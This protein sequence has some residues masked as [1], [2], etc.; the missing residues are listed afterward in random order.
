MFVA[1]DMGNHFRI[2][3]DQRDLNYDLYFNKG[4]NNLKNIEDYNSNNARQLSIAEIKKILLT[5]DIFKNK[6]DI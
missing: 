4:I 3:S 6:I 1:K 5:L 2:G